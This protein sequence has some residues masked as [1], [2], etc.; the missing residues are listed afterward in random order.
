MSPESG[1]NGG[2][3]AQE[4]AQHEVVDLLEPRDGLPPVVSTPAALAEAIAKLSG[5]SGP[6]AVDAERAS[7]YRYGQRAYLV[8]LR[9]Q[10]A[11]TVLIDPIACP[12]LR[13]LGTALDDIEAVLHA[14]SQDL[15]CLAEVGYRPQ[16]LFDTELAG[17]LLGYPRVALGTLIEEILGFRLA[18]EHS[19]ADWSARPLSEEMLR[20]AALDV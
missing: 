2:N 15:P 12:D 6:V 7:G 16:R 18:K 4:T 3:S 17:R 20:Y 14:A 19:A 13:G 5:G 8:Q 11:G 9:R 10:G 1:Q